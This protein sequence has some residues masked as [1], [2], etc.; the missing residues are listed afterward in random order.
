MDELWYTL[1]T[2]TLF[3]SWTK[4]FCPLISKSLKFYQGLPKDKQLQWCQRS[5]SVLHAAFSSISSFCYVAIIHVNDFQWYTTPFC[6]F[7]VAIVCGYLL[8][9]L[10]VLYLHGN[11]ADG[12][13]ISVAH[14]LTVVI[15]GYASLGNGYLTYMACFRVLAEL[16]TPFMHFRWYLYISGRTKES[17][18]FW[19]GLI[20]VSFFFLSRIAIIPYFYY[21]V[22]HIAKLE[23]YHNSVSFA[24]QCC[25][26]TGCIFLDLLNIYWFWKIIKRAQHTLKHEM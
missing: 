19:N 2:G 6:R 20:F 16:S 14:H 13:K 4:I 15:A 9:D 5:T 24:F 25:W 18:Y 8:Q 17:I 23:D 10:I 1:Y 12:N 21:V 26:I 11:A 7:N 3:I 22:Y